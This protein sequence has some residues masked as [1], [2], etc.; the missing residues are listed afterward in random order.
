[1]DAGLWAGKYPSV[2]HHEYFA[3]G[4]QSWFD[5][6][7]EDDH[8]HNHVDTRAELKAYD[9]GLAAICEEVF[10]ETE[11]V[12]VRPPERADQ[13]HLEGYNY[14]DAPDFSLAGS[15]EN[16][17]YAPQTRRWLELSYNSRAG[18][19]SR[20]IGATS[21]AIS[22]LAWALAFVRTSQRSELAATTRGFHADSSRRTVTT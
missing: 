10:G 16:P 6:N 9:P 18:S 22:S 14:D 11:L 15:P 21:K 17:G 13:A 19:H 1:M 4:V 5:N 3:E 8:D 2:N 7:R 20:A 12:Y